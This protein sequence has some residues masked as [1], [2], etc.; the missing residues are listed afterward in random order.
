MTNLVSKPP[1]FNEEQLLSSEKLDDLIEYLDKQCEELRN[2][3]FN[4]LQKLTKCPK[5]ELQ[6]KEAD[7]MALIN[8]IKSL[9][10]EMTINELE[11]LEASITKEE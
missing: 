10:S 3:L 9:I 4:K 6:D 7:R 2:N 8:S 1:D 5:R 11:D